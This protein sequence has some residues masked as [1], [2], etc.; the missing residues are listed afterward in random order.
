MRFEELRT[1]ALVLRREYVDRVRSVSF[2]VTTFAVPA[3][4]LALAAFPILFA[5]APPSSPERVV[6]AS[7]LAEPAR[8]IADTLRH[9]RTGHYVPEI[10][11]NTT[12]QE[13]AQLT[14][15]VRD[16]RIEGFLWLDSAALRS[17]RI[18]YTQCLGERRNVAVMPADDQHLPGILRISEN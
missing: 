14:A 6:L 17:G 2:L 16:S 7:G 18:V 11:L 5:G 8:Q 9:A 3:M 12:P 1:L 10:V 4:F 15:M 13:H